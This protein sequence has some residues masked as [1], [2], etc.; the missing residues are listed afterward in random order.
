[1]GAHLE[2]PAYYRGLLRLVIAD[3]ERGYGFVSLVQ[4]Q[5][6]LQIMRLAIGQFLNVFQIAQTARTSLAR[7]TLEMPDDFSCRASLSLLKSG[8]VCNDASQSW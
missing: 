3:V 8:S 7:M 2:T 1:M 6:A 4:R 5:A